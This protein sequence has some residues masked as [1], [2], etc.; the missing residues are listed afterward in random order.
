[1]VEWGGQ[2]F[3]THHLR[4]LASTASMGAKVFFNNIH[5]GPYTDTLYTQLN[6]FYDM[7]EKGI[8]PIPGR[9]ELLFLS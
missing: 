5:A 8:I 3:I 4:I 6:T 2:Q 9:D 7:L 1:M